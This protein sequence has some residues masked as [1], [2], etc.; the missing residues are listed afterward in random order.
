MTDYEKALS[1]AVLM[2][3]HESSHSKAHIA[4]IARL[5]VQVVTAMAP[6]DK[7]L[8]IDEARLVR[9][10]EGL[11]TWRVGRDFVIDSDEDHIQWLPAKRGVIDWKFWNRYRRY[12][13]V[14]PKPLAPVVV[15]SVDDLTDRVLERVED[16]NRQGPW[17]RR[18]MIV[19]H[20]QSGKTSNFIGLICKAADAGYKIII[21]L[22]G[23]TENLRT[24]T[25]MRVDEGFL[26]YSAA[27][28]TTFSVMNQPI[29]VGMLVTNY[30]APANSLTGYKQDFSRTAARGLNISPFGQDPVILVVKKNKAILTN[31]ITWLAGYADSDAEHPKRKSPLPDVPLLVIDDEADHA[32]INTKLIPT[33][34]MT[35]SPQDDYDVTAINGRVRQLLSLFSKKSYVGYTATPFANIFIHPEDRLTSGIVGTP[36]NEIE[37]PFGEGLFPRSFIISLPVPT[38]YVGP[39]TIFGMDSNPEFGVDDGIEALP[40]IREVK[41]SDPYIPRNHKIDCVPESLPASLKRAIRSFILTCAARAHRGAGTEHNSMLIHVTRFISVQRV[42]QELVAQELKDLTNRLRYGDGASASQVM[43]ELEALWDEDFVPTTKAVLARINDP[44][45]IKAEWEDVKPLLSAAAQKVAVKRISG[46]SDDVLDYQNSPDGASVIAIGGDKLSRGLTL[47]GLSVSYFLRPSKMYDTLMQMG[48]WFGYRPGYLDLCRLYTPG[49]LAEWYKH[50]A[51]AA[52]ELRQEFE[53]MVDANKTPRDYGLRVRSHP[54]GLWI[55]SLVKMRESQTLTVSYDGRIS[56]TTVFQRDEAIT[57]QNL[58]AANRFLSN[59]PKLNGDP[60]V[61]SGISANAVLSFLREYRTHPHAPK[62][63][64][65]LLAHYIARKSA[66]G[67]LTNWTVV[68]VSS[69]DR[70]AVRSKELSYPVGLIRRT[71]ETADDGSVKYTVQRLLSPTDEEYGLTPAAIEDALRETRVAWATRPPDKRSKDEPREPSGPALRKERSLKEG[72]LLLYPLDPSYAKLPYKIPVVGLGISFPGDR[73]NPTDG[74]EYEAN[75][76]YVGKELGDDDYD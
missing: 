19:G 47:E 18:G 14:K 30:R 15:D 1:H 71:N 69:R 49:D 48:R 64:S 39:V 17:D 45:I 46:G 59:L 26:G 37:I 73:L 4:E 22:A 61:W 20:V 62:V 58:D 40:V 65:A 72:L 60:F 38:N 41:D 42:I 56:E 52:E 11:V 34:P 51:F 31:L 8:E 2:L 50:I 43:G 53:L 24:Q 5:A 23:T 70:E 35:G 9:E 10:L 21:V 12:L 7:P 57:K 13:T 67:F 32:S 33:D 63:N 3:G 36:P 66:K 6:K 29:G 54:N 55:T 68:L 75:L 74:V 44:L 28:A 27:Q 16:P 25:Q 76:V